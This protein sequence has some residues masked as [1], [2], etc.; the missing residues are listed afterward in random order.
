MLQ[1][2]PRVPPETGHLW[3]NSQERVVSEIVDVGIESRNESE[4]IVTI[5]PFPTSVLEECCHAFINRH[6]RLRKVSSP[7]A[8]L[9][10]PNLN[11]QCT[12]SE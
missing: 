1:L 12:T 3:G 6:V 11:R 2:D 7:E 8:F 9:L 4:N 5:V 10:I